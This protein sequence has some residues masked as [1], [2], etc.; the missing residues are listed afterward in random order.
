MKIT[1]LQEYGLRILLQLA[2]GRDSKEPVRIRAIAEKEALSV[3]Y[4]EKILTRLR[5]GGLVKSVRGL[6]G[7]YALVAGP[8]KIS[9]GEAMTALTERP[10]QMNRLK[11]DLCGQFPGNRMECVHLRGCTIRQ[12]WSM[13]VMQI[14]SNLNRI[15]LSDL[16]G[17][18]NEVQARLM[19]MI[20]KMRAG[21]IG[22]KKEIVT[23]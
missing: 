18:E 21:E 5:R 13:V 1:A 3:D 15:F 22:G 12:V 11:K 20:Q 19:P 7:G 23:I 8:D 17:S 14:Y 2:E 16:I 4:V 9:L 10:I 6:K